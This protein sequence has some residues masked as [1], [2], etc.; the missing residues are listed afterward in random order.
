[1]TV[2]RSVSPSVYTI[3]S[4]RS[5]IRCQVPRRVATPHRARSHGQVSDPSRASRVRD[6]RRARPPVARARV[7]D[8]AEAEVV[9]KDEADRGQIQK[10]T[11]IFAP[12]LRP[13]WYL[14][15]IGAIRRTH[16]ASPPLKSHLK[17]HPR[18]RPIRSATK[19]AAHLCLRHHREP[20]V[21]AANRHGPYIRPGRRSEPRN[22]MSAAD[23]RR[24]KDR[25]IVEVI[26][27]AVSQV[28]SDPRD[29]TNTRVS[30][31]SR[32]SPPRP[33]SP[34][35]RLTPFASR[36]DD[37]RRI[38]HPRSMLTWTDREDESRCRGSRP[39]SQ[40]GQLRWSSAQRPGISSGRTVRG[41][42][43]LRSLR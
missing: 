36:D 12:R 37:E 39:A 11:M 23:E 40:P 27:V 18:K 25:D 1:M 7:A 3:R 33:S 26:V 28:P 16:F 29:Q 10:R 41:A 35:V 6:P 30:R 21:R 42:R 15:W 8:T 43:R 17:I 38:S 34:S 19:Q 31:R 4:P 32:T 24:S 14:V 13:K 5:W 2:R 9:N 22:P 20:A